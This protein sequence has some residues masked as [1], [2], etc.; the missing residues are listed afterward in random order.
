MMKKITSSVKRSLQKKK[1][2][3]R[4]LTTEQKEDGILNIHCLDT[5]NV[6]DYYCAPYHYFK[7]LNK[8]ALDIFDYDHKDK[9]VVDNFVTKVSANNLIVGGGGLLNRPAFNKQMGVFEKL[10][11]K[12]KKVVL[13]G[14]GHNSKYQKDFNNIKHY[15]IDMNNFKLASTRDYSMPGEFVPCV[16]C[17][18]P[19]F[20]KAY[21]ETQDVGIVFHLDT[22]KKPEILEKFKDYPSANNTNDL[23]HLISFIGSS[24]KIVTDS[25]HV[26][27]WSMLLGKKVVVI[28]NS[29]KFYDFKYSTPISDFDNALN[30]FHKAEVYSGLLEECRT[31]NKDF[32][33]KVFD[34]LNL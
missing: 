7:E 18:H 2:L 21:T 26:M 12:G 30:Q 31:I 27:Y 34:Y 15:N 8:E 32:S 5:P 24:N 6:G 3:Q 29:S 22:A 25:Y 19:I 28:P 13:W 14:I 16:S 4:I 33:N 9:A 10:S 17:L 1:T 20:D 11:K 23:N